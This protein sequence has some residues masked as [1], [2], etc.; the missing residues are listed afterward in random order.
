MPEHF[1][2][3]GR[4][5]TGIPLT[6]TITDTRES[7]GDTASLVDET[8]FIDIQA[9][10]SDHVRIEP[11]WPK[12]LVLSVLRTAPVEQLTDAAEDEVKVSVTRDD[13]SDEIFRGYLV[14][15]RYEDE[16][17]LPYEDEVTLTFDEGIPILKGES[18]GD[19]SFADDYQVKLVEIVRE[20]LDAIYQTALPIEVAM[21]WWPNSS[22]LTSSDLPLEYTWMDPDNFREERPDGDD[23]LTQ[24]E[25]LK[26]ILQAFGMVCRQVERGGELRWHLRCPYAINGSGEVPLWLLQPSGSSTYQGEV[27]LLTDITSKVNDGELRREHGRT[28]E[29]GRQETRLLHDH[30]SDLNYVREGGFEE[31]GYYWNN[32]AAGASFNSHSTDNRTPEGSVE[33]QRFALISYDSDS[34]GGSLNYQLEQE[35]EVVLPDD[36][37]SLRL[38]WEQWQSPF[39]PSTVGD[40]MAAR[41]AIELTDG[42]DRLGFYA[43]E[44]L[45]QFEAGETRLRVDPLAD[46]IYEGQRLPI[47]TGAGPWSIEDV[48]THL[49]VQETTEKESTTVQC[50]LQNSVQPGD[51]L[52][53]PS[54]GDSH[55]MNYFPAYLLVPGEEHNEWQQ[56]TVQFALTDDNGNAVDPE[57]LTIRLG[58]EEEDHDIGVLEWLFDNVTLQPQRN[59]TGLDETLSS[60]KTDGTGEN[61]EITTRVGSGPSEDNTA[62]IFGQGFWDSRFPIVSAD[63]SANEFVVEGD[64]TSDFTDGEVIFARKAGINNGRFTITSL[65][66]SSTADETT[67][68]VQGLQLQDAGPGGFIVQ[69]LQSQFTAFR[70]GIGP[71]ASETY[72][73]SELLARERLRYMR[74]QNRIL[75]IEPYP[76]DEPLFFHGH[77]VVEVDGTLYTMSEAMATPSQGNRPIT[78]LELTDYGTA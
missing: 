12:D 16:P 63:L 8:R 26:N 47:F 66:Y 25:V 41:T 51:F 1:E 27:S 42:T 62:R 37:S 28:F 64:A 78:L 70:W 34:G 30:E 58:F 35:F 52:G 20:S 38:Q 33:N 55:S 23:W 29:Q 40:D 68:G 75:Q 44:V 5:L 46:T 39:V 3:S 11:M 32:I 73:L 76:S 50:E 15:R 54:F 48:R 65:A 10:Q 19:F 61:D 31:V 9:G 2:A 45:Y 49:E 36:K 13:T 4:S 43:T 74:Q 72:P 14:P 53:I 6:A 17:F 77:E 7:S 56:A 21:R 59:G 57:S 60:V 24:F 71:S 69:G 18:A 67:I 22:A